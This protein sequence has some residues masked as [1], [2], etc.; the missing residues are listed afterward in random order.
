MWARFYPHHS[1][2]QQHSPAAFKTGSKREQYNQKFSPSHRM[3]FFERLRRK[4]S[5]SLSVYL[6]PV[7][8]IRESWQTLWF[9]FVGGETFMLWVVVA[10]RDKRKIKL[11]V[12]ASGATWRTLALK[13]FCFYYTQVQLNSQSISIRANVFKD[14]KF[15]LKLS[16]LPIEILNIKNEGK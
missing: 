6:A 3:A 12:R 7:V 1:E 4:Q 11:T 15:R 5:F 14:E 10:A 16:F 9:V 2:Q 8:V 13:R